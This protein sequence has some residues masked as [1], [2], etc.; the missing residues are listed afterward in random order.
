MRVYFIFSVFDRNF[1]YLAEC[2]RREYPHARF[3]GFAYNR[4]QALANPVFSAIDFASDME[5]SA[6]PGSYDGFF[7]EMEQQFGVLV[8]ELIHMDRHSSRYASIVRPAIAGKFM[9]TFVESLNRHQI[10]LVISEGVDDL[11]SFFAM[12]Y[13]ERKGIPFVAPLPGRQGNAAILG[14]RDDTEPAGFTDDLNRAR[15]GYDS[16][17]IAEAGRRYI[18]QYLSRQTRPHYTTSGSL[19]YRPWSFKDLRIGWDYTLQY[20]RDKGHHHIVHP[21]VLPFNRLR[22]I[23]RKARYEQFVQRATAKS[24]ALEPFKYFVYPIH[25]HPESATLVMGRKFYNQVELVKAISQSLP[26]GYRLLVKE[27]RVNLGRRPLSYYQAISDFHNV[28]LVS[29]DANVFELLR[30]SAGVTTISSSMALE[31]LMLGKPVLSF[32]TPYYNASRNVYHSLDF[33]QLPC[34]IA[35]LISHQYDVRDTELFFG[36]LAR[37]LID[38]GNITQYYGVNRSAWDKIYQ[39]I[40]S[41]YLVGLAERRLANNETGQNADVQP[42]VSAVNCNMEMPS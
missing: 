25:F 2:I 30:N 6:R 16:E 7:A 14:E 31:A 42:A 12:K 13:C 15:S 33:A 17:A 4:T 23:Y 9:S 32:G 26:A 20:F 39:R 21:L 38:C 35:K 27:H 37:H 41:R 36:T 34:M 24:R 11:I 8:A 18:V 40:R 28:D 5:F 19:I 1:E 29:H 22:R 10:D 3:H